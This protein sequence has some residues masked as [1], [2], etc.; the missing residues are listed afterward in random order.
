MIDLDTR[1]AVEA[2]SIGP[3]EVGNCTLSF[4]RA[5]ALDQLDQA[6]GLLAEVRDLL[7]RRS[8]CDFAQHCQR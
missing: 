2:V 4:D 5:I 7:E 3:N 8:R 6:A 1:R